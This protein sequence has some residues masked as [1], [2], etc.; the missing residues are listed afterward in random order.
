M[1][2][3]SFVVKCNRCRHQLLS[4]SLLSC[5]LD[6]RGNWNLTS[7]EDNSHFKVETAGVRCDIRTV[8]GKGKQMRVFILGKRKGGG[9][10]KR[11]DAGQF[12]L[13]V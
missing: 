11:P 6:H 8:G 3:V 13:L 1:F 4:L 2:A 5:P 10:A 9:G 7:E 12:N